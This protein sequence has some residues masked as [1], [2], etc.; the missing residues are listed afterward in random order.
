VQQLLHYC[1]GIRS[2]AVRQMSSSSRLVEVSR[3][4]PGD[5]PP[6]LSVQAETQYAGRG[7]NTASSRRPVPA[8]VLLAPR[9]FRRSRIRPTRK[10]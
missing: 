3:P 1:I 4:T 5:W 8:G 10:E 2:L 7:P 9:L 6:H